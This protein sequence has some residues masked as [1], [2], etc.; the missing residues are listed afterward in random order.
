MVG[1]GPQRCRRGPLLEHLA[2]PGQRPIQNSRALAFQRLDEFRVS[3]VFGN[4]HGEW[5]QPDTPPYRVVGPPDFGLMIRRQEQ[6]ELRV[7]LEKLAGDP[8]DIYVN[9]RPVARGEVLVLND[10][11]CVRVNEILENTAENAERFG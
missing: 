11:F 7:E 6:L 2:Q 9:D 3:V 1:A 4:C 5:N 8:V 10:N